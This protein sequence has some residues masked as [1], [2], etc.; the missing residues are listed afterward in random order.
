MKYKSV[1]TTESKTECNF[2]IQQSSPHHRLLLLRLFGYHHR[3]HE[4]MILS[5]F[6]VADDVWET[7]TRIRFDLP[8]FNADQRIKRMIILVDGERDTMRRRLL[9]RNEEDDGDEE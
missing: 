9:N 6:F 4:T 2:L 8:S 3:H 5:V 7:I 1:V